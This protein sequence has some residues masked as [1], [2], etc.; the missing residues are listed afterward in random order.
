MDRVQNLRVTDAIGT[1]TN[2][3]YSLEHQQDQASVAR[4]EAELVRVHT[5]HARLYSEWIAT[6]Q[7]LLAK[8]A[9]QDHELQQ[10]RWTPQTSSR[11]GT[12]GN[13]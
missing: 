9:E 6:E 7:D 11:D 13:G 5:D 2:W 3:S 10:L 4:L 12:G 8:I 1:A